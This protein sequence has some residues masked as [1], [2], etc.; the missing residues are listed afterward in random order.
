MLGKFMTGAVTP[1]GLRRCQRGA[2]LFLD[3]L[4]ART[5]GWGRL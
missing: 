2:G 5:A 4:L 1:D 3:R